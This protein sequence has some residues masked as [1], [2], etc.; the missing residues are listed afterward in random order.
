MQPTE[1]LT[2]D[3]TSLFDTSVAFIHLFMSRKLEALGWLVEQ[4]DNVFV[5]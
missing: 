5:Q 2:N 3:S 4:G 1:L